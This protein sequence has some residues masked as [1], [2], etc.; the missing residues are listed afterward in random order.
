MAVPHLFVEYS[1]NVAEHVDID[2][3]VRAVHQAALAT[4]VPP[5]AGLR[6]RAVP[7]EQ[8]RIATGES[9]FA[10]IAISARLGPGRDAD[11]KTAFLHAVLDAAEAC[12]TTQLSGDQLA[13]AWSIEL[14]EIDA[15]F[16]INR[17]H[18]RP[19]LSESS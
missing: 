10:F 4:G 7:R 1:N 15:D 12:V 5:L 3:L 2:D 17:N 14:T 11:T 18:I 19:L 8:Y 6:T 13:I 9:K 16:R